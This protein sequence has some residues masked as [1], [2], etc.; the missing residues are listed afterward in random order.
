[1]QTDDVTARNRALDH[2]KSG[3]AA[4]LWVDRLTG[5]LFILSSPADFPSFQQRQKEGAFV[6]GVDLIV[7]VTDPLIV[8]QVQR[9]NATARPAQ[10]TPM[11]A[12]RPHQRE[13]HL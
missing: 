10:S 13:A 6:G 9:L 5:R 11:A 12:N 1:M 7:E 8:K 4:S 3:T 2:I